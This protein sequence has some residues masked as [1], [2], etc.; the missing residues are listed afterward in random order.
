MQ[1]DKLLNIIKMKKAGLK[2]AA[3]AVVIA[4]GLS[5]AQLTYAQEETTGKYRPKVEFEKRFSANL[6]VEYEKYCSTKKTTQTDMINEAVSEG[7]FDGEKAE[8]VI[9]RIQ[10]SECGIRGKH[11][12]ARRHIVRSKFFEENGEEVAEFLGMTVEELEIAHQNGERLGDLLEE[13]G[14]DRDE[15]HEFMQGLRGID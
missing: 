3:V 14:I 11:P 10:Q 5:M 2:I 8:K 6:G 9:E 4:A 1:I 13:K 7:K 15:F 12:L